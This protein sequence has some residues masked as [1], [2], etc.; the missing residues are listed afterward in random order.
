MRFPILQARTFSSSVRYAVSMMNFVT[1]PNVLAFAV[2]YCI[3]SST[4][5]SSPDFSAAI[6]MTKSIS[7]ARARRAHFSFLDFGKCDA[8][9]KSDDG[10]DLHA[11]ITEKVARHWNIRWEDEHG[12]HPVFKCFRAQPPDVISVATRAQK[13]AIDLR[14]SQT[15]ADDELV[16]DLESDVIH[17]PVVLRIARLLYR[18]CDPKKPRSPC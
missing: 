17:W 13:R 10:R 9:W 15:E 16:R 2:R 7:S 4:D 5:L 6:L 18:C 14:V 12:R 11:R 1:T 3:S 8:E